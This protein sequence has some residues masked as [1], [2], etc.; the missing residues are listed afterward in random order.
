MQIVPLLFEIAYADLQSRTPI[1]VAVAKEALD[2][3]EKERKS[4]EFIEVCRLLENNVFV[5]EFVISALS[6]IPNVGVVEDLFRNGFCVLKSGDEVIRLVEALNLDGHFEE[7]VVREDFVFTGFTKS[8][9][10]DAQQVFFASKTKE[11]GID[12]YTI[13]I[14]LRERI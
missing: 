10:G 11:S 2:Q 4:D 3:I 12:R 9:L 1:E 7:G 5:I 8:E 6:K 13:A 14:C